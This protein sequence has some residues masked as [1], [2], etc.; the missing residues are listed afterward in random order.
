MRERAKLS[1][2]CAING[3]QVTVTFNQAVD[4]LSLAKSNFVVTQEGDASG[5]DR[6]TDS[7]TAT[8]IAVSGQVVNTGV[9]Q[10]NGNTVTLTVDTGAKM[11]NGKT[12]TIKTTGVKQGTDTMADVTKTAVLSDTTVPTIVSATSTGSKTFEVVFSEPVYD[13]TTDAYASPFSTTLTN[14]LSLN[15]YGVAIASVQRTSANPNALIVT[16]SADL[17]KGTA[18][19]LKVNPNTFGLIQDYA[20]YKLIV[21]SAIT[22]THTV[23]TNLPVVTSAEAKTEKVVRLTFDRSVT[24]PGSS[25]IEFRYAF[26]ATGAVKTNPSLGSVVAVENTNNTQWDVTL[27]S[28]MTPGSGTMYI[29]YVAAGTVA[30]NNVIY[31]AYGN[32]L[33][34]DAMVSFTVVQDTTAP[35]AVVAYNSATTLD[36]TFSKSVTGATNSANYELKDPNGNV[37]AISGIVQQTPTTGNKYRLTVATMEAGGNYTLAITNGIKDT[38]VYQT[39]FVPTTFTVAVT[40]TKAP[41]IS[42]VLSNNTTAVNGDVVY[43]YYSETMGSSATT[44][45]NY[46]LYDGTTQYTLPSGTVITQSGTTVKIALPKTLAAI[47]TDLSSGALDELYVGS[48]KDLAGNTVNP[49]GAR[50]INNAADFIAT[51]TKT[52]VLADTQISFV[53]DRQLKFLDASKIS[54]GSVGATSASF[55]NNS[56]G[57]ATVTAYFAADTYSTYIPAT[58][59]TVETTAVGAFTDLNDVQSATVSTPVDITIDRAA[60][61]FV[62]TSPIKTAGLSGH[63]TGITV[64]Y[65]EDIY[66]ASVAQSD[67]TVDGYTI[68]GVSVSGPTV[69]LTVAQ[70]SGYDIRCL[71][72]RQDKGGSYSGWDSH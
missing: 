11:I 70:K 20:G 53:V 49:M 32:I 13:G 2:F 33:A 3:K 29:H 48:V 15:D 6:I 56:D 19:T 40:D 52:K 44:T 68:T 66:A 39:A 8:N 50:T 24:I 63:V 67:Y 27:P 25:N 54:N 18:Y 26:N 21:N 16:T 28:A 41:T 58:E 42:S 31:D 62:A 43:V 60:P 72:V 22:F 38:T 59:E 71:S 36:V 35:T 69:T 65:S 23:S 45:D 47:A 7:D 14:N 64:T 30:N 10:V 4:T 51:I 46:R 57:T 1:C 17:V 5:T 61:K 55:V 34:N 9:V 12:I 37:V